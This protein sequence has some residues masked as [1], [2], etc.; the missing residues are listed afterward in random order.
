MN[1]RSGANEVEISRRVLDTLE[2]LKQDN[3]SMNYMV[4]YEA[5]DYIMQVANNA[6][7]KHCD[8]CRA[9]GTGGFALPPPGGGYCYHL[10]LHA[11]LRADSVP[12]DECFWH[13]A[14]YDEFGRHCNV[15]RH[16][17]GQ[18]HRGLWRI[19]IATLGMDTADMIAAFLGTS[20]VITSITA[21]V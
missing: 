13:N 14:E 6:I 18:L 21:S 3:P 7:Q 15:H 20:E 10:A 8:G 17:G 2:E 5:S 11:I 1:K 12:A 19:S 9:L 16:G 4:P